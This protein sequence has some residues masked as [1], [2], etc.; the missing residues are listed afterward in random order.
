MANFSWRTRLF[1]FNKNLRQ[2]AHLYPP[3]VQRLIHAEAFIAEFLTPF[4][5]AGLLWLVLKTSWAGLLQNIPGLLLLGTALFLTQRRPFQTEITI[6]S[7]EKLPVGMSLLSI[8]LWAGYFVWGR[9]VLWLSLMVIILDVA[10]EARRLT[11]LQQDPWVSSAS[12]FMQSNQLLGSL[13]ALWLFEQLG[14]SF[15]FE[16][17]LSWS[18][19]PLFL[20]PIFFE[21]F[22]QVAQIYGAIQ[23]Y[24]FCV[25]S[26]DNRIDLTLS[27]FGG[28]I[29][30]SLTAVFAILGA[31]AYSW[32][33]AW[34]FFL[35][36]IAVVLA[37]ALLHNLSKS[38]ARTA[39]RAREM[40]EL[41]ALGQ[42]ILKA[43]PGHIPLYDLL[44]THLPLMFPN[45][46]IELRLTT[47]QPFHIVNPP[48]RPTVRPDVWE[49]FVASP[50]PYLIR[51]DLSPPLIDKP[52]GETVLL[53]ISVIEPEGHNVP[54]SILG[55]I[56]LV[57]WRERGRSRESL[58]ALQALASQIATAVY[59][60]EAFH[61][62]LEHQKTARELEV[63]GQIQSSFLPRETPIFK[64]WHITA[65][66][67]PARQTSGD[68][69]DFIS[70]P[71]GRLGLLIADVAD[72]GT[73]AALYMALSR[74]LLRTFAMAHPD[75]PALVLQAAN[76]RILADTAADQFVTVFY[77]VIEPDG[78][79][80]YSSGGHNPTLLWPFDRRSE[81]QWLGQTGIPLGMFEE[82]NWEE[83]AVNLAAGDL[84]L[85]YTDGVTEAQNP[86]AE[87]F[88][89]ER[90]VAT[91]Q[92]GNG[93]EPQQLQAQLLEDIHTFCDGAPQFDDITLVIAQHVGG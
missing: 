55:T 50:E 83:K 12:R 18:L 46:R 76:E 39:Q 77:G 24:N 6:R 65:D 58:P 71:N 52:L 59:R 3:N 30:F 86:A 17:L 60:Q 54:N 62:T 1:E 47:P 73:G 87:E 28:L 81:P 22:I 7:G 41:E 61:Q 85:L 27:W 16:P 31:I 8:L 74:T 75:Q 63:A 32:G 49:E 68:F 79:L 44:S 70:L 33:G 53:K 15:P 14:G 36:I 45:D 4:F 20:L 80:I 88:G 2:D 11:R 19:L 38:N 56:G 82:M 72:K 35:F 64:N 25:P 29:L 66:I 21:L 37:N 43:D 93:V 57:R 67:K 89:E 69:Y 26:P 34:P 51:D 42:A 78:R 40:A 90:L 23:F 13:S 9:H 5:A 92:K 91:V 10:V 48:D 84:L